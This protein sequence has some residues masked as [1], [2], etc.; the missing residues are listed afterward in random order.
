M[1]VRE[2]IQRL[3]N[4]RKSG[5]RTAAQTLGSRGEDIVA[6][7]V[8]QDLRMKVV[9]RNQ[10]FIGGELD[11]VAIDGHDL[12]FIEVR[13]R[14]S[15]NAGAPELTVGAEKRRFL[16]RSA[17]KFISRR[18]LTSFTPRFDIAAVLWPENGQPEI[19]YHKNAFPPR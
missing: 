10:R 19:R 15:D 1:A 3:L 17:R 2:L 12:A 11:I 16:R 5:A 8:Q 4:L 7:H 13:T 9:A 18:R 14:R 6:R